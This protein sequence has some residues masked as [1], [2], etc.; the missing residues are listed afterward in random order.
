MKEEVIK[1]QEKRCA[2]FFPR[3]P[4]PPQFYL[5]FMAI[6]CNISRGCVCTHICVVLCKKSVSLLSLFSV[7]EA[8][9]SPAIKSTKSI[10]VSYLLHRD[11]LSIAS[12]S[13]ST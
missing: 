3:S 2:H 13:S 10:C 9:I 8:C 7:F 6:S 4:F 12:S 11:D 5:Y 1:V